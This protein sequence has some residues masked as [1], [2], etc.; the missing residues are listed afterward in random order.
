MWVSQHKEETSSIV[1]LAKSGKSFDKYSEAIVLSEEEFK[2][3]NQMI[4]QAY[5]AGLDAHI[6]KNPYFLLSKLKTIFRFLETLSQ[7]T[8]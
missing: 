1:A 4:L 5:K 6:S 2:L 3:S 7:K 8:S